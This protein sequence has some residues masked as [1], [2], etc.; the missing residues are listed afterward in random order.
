M[1]VFHFPLH[2][3]L[4][5]CA[6]ASGPSTVSWLANM[7]SAASQLRAMEGCKSASFRLCNIT[8]HHDAASRW[9][10]GVCAELFIRPAPT[11][12]R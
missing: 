11:A 9:L 3:S 2:T 10:R 4:R 8:Y 12:A 6:K 1:D 7:R 5:F